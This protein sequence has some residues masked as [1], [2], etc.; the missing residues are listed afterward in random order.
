M[1]V[2][3]LNVCFLCLALAPAAE[4]GEKSVEY[5]FAAE[6]GKEEEEQKQAEENTD[7]DPCDS[8]GAQTAVLGR[9][10]DRAARGA[11]RCLEGFSGSCCSGRGNGR[12]GSASWADK[13]RVARAGSSCNSALSCIEAYLVGS[14]TEITPTEVLPR[15]A[16]AA[17][18]SGKYHGNGGCAGAWREGDAVC[19][20]D[21]LQIGFDVGCGVDLVVSTPGGCRG[22]LRCFV[23]AGCDI[24]RCIAD[25][26]RRAAILIIEATVGSAS[27]VPQFEGGVLGALEDGGE[28]VAG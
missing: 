12:R 2:V 28:F 25:L 27:A 9:G 8:T 26:A 14:T 3:R 7:N 19:G 24:V 17:C 11:D 22:C 15:G 20:C 21:R 23:G 1:G 4:K 5:A 18:R 13:C 6:T 16:R 10:G